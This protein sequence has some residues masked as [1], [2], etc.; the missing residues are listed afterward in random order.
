LATGRSI[1][2]P[3]STRFDEISLS[4]RPQGRGLDLRE[5]RPHYCMANCGC[6]RPPG[7]GRCRNSPVITSKVAADWTNCF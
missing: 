6:F 4:A 3:L 5:A 7:T 1:A 2:P